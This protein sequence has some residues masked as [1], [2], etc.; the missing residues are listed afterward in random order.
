M[1]EGKRERDRVV[2]KREERGKERRE[3]DMKGIRVK[4]VYSEN[5][6]IGREVEREEND[7]DKF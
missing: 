1:R 4:D 5:K 2:E 6:K 7:E 3:G